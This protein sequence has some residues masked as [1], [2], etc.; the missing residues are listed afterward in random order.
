MTTRAARSAI[1]T[2][3][4][5]GIA[6]LIGV[7]VLIG[8]GSWQIER[9]AWK[10]ALIATLTER[11]TQPPAPLPLPAAW[12]RLT[13]AQDE[14]RRV[15]FSAAFLHDQEAHVYTAG[16]ALRADVSGPGYWVFTPAKLP[17]GALVMVDRGF[18]PEGSRD[19]KTRPQGQVPGEIRIVGAL[20]WPEEPTWFTPDPDPARNLWFRRDPASM[21]E[22][23]KTGPIAPFYV[24]QEA[25]VPPGGLPK[26]GPLTANLRN[27]H[28]QYAWTWYGLAVVLIVVFMSWV[29]SRRRAV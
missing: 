22:A 27:P 3:A 9:K 4:V 18:V 29:V 8:L 15:A 23:K 25:P 11:L 17:G 16:S 2:W 5:P 24:V 14:F 20:R 13:A 28:L 26:P 21:A 7:G 1:R 19:P 10:E 12:G 6:A